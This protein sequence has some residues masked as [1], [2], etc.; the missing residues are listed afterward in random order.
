[1]HRREVTGLEE[2]IGRPVPRRKPS[3]RRADGSEEAV[4]FLPRTHRRRIG[5]EAEVTAVLE[6]VLARTGRP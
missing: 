6:P 5:D 3:T 2:E 4:T 1:M